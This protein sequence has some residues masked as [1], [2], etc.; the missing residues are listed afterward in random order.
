LSIADLGSTEPNILEESEELPSNQPVAPRQPAKNE[1]AQASAQ[2]APTTLRV[3]NF[4]G[5]SVRA[6]VEEAAA[7]GLPV[8]VDG[9]GTARG[10]IPLAG[11]VLEKG[12]RIR[13]QFAR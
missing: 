2:R 7:M 12:E 10:Q 13:V 5:M 1:I 8:V 6:V 11:S 9:S 4:Q 3:P